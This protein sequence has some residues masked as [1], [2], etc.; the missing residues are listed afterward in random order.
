[1]EGRS[2]YSFFDI[3]FFGPKGFLRGISRGMKNPD[4]EVSEIG[5]L[6]IWRIR[7]DERTIKSKKY[8]YSSIYFTLRCS[9]VYSILLPIAFVLRYSK[10]QI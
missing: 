1:M 3:F 2:C 7:I 6:L 10:S 4:R 9:G 5:A 8:F